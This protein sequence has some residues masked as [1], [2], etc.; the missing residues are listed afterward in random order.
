[1]KTKKTLVPSKTR[2]ITTIFQQSKTSTTA[3]ITTHN[4]S[5]MDK[6]PTTMSP[7]TTTIII[8][9]FLGATVVELEEAITSLV[10]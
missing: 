8:K 10:K 5:L 7:L 3:S 9:L 4:F 6:F 2:L 1:M